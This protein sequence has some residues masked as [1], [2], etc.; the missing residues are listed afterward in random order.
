MFRYSVHEF[1]NAKPE[2]CFATYKSKEEAVANLEEYAK[3]ISG[4][5]SIPA[6]VSPME[7][8]E[9]RQSRYWKGF[10]GNLDI[11]AEDCDKDWL[12]EYSFY[13]DHKDTEVNALRV[14]WE[15]HCH[16]EDMITDYCARE[17]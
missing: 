9:A 17:Y 4:S 15:E 13:V 6:E 2:E 12:E 7:Y 11:A 8:F 1:M 14:A 3:Y 5:V 16:I 10:E